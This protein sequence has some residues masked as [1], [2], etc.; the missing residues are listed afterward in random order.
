M[1]VALMS[2][3][4]AVIAFCL[5]ASAG[6][7]IND[8]LDAAKDRAHP[9]KCRR[10]IAAGRLSPS[11]AIAT[12]IA[13]AAAGLATTLLAHR[14]QLTLCV[15][16]YLTMTA[17]YTYKLTHVPV[18][19]MATVAAGFL[20]RAVTGAVAVGAV[21]SSWF[22]LVALY[23]APLPAAVAEVTELTK[24]AP[25]QVEVDEAHEVA[26]VHAWHIAA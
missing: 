16:T 18:M 17:S 3:I 20:L 9:E 19:D 4:V 2:T 5:S 12:G 22:F 24:A 26:E 23:E 10:P 15:A 6:Y 7:F 8:T 11:F 21:I 13:L 25:R 14:W 1:S